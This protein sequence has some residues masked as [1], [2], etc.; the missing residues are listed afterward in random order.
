MSKITKSDI[1]YLFEDLWPKM[2]YAQEHKRNCLNKWSSIQNYFEKYNS[3][4][5][6]NDLLVGLDS[7]DGIGITIGTGLIWSAHR[8]DRVPFDKYT[9]TYSIQQKVIKTEKI[10]TNYIEISEQLKEFCDGFEIDGRNYQI[11]DFVREAM[12]ELEGREYLIEPI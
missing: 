7:L 8:L 2:P 12:E 4:E 9:L 5:Q 10:S 1:H 6:H 11:E 3:P